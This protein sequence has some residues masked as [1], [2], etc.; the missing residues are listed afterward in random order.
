VNQKRLQQKRIDQAEDGRVGPNSQ[1]QDR[2]SRE[3]KP[4]ILAEHSRAEAHL[5]EQIAHVLPPRSIPASFS[6]Y[7]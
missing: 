7:G 6:Y 1:G 2:H 4:R 3:G 5:A